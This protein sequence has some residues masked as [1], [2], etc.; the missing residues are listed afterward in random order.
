MSQAKTIQLTISKL[1]YDSWDD[2]YG[3]VNDSGFEVIDGCLDGPDTA[4]LTLAKFSRSPIDKINLS[5]F[6]QRSRLSIGNWPGRLFVF[7]L[8]CGLRCCCSVG[9]FDVTISDGS[10]D[11]SFDA[12]LR[13]S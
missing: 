8:Y 7:L 4:K 2:I 5:M 10:I 11:W 1:S 13:L 12:H 3:I 9:A 6:S